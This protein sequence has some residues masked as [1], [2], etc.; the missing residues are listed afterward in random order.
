L[1]DVPE[2]V[3]TE[4][5]IVPIGDLKPHPRNARRGDVAKIRES[6]RAHGVFAPVLAQR[7]RARVIAHRHVWEACKAE[8]MTHV[9]VIWLDVNDREAERIM[10]ADNGTSD[11]A[12]YDEAALLALLEPLHASPAGLYGTSFDDAAMDRLRARVEGEGVVVLDGVDTFT[13]SDDD[14]RA[15]ARIATT[16]VV[17]LTASTE[18]RAELNALLDRARDESGV[19]EPIVLVLSA[20]RA[21]VT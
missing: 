21:F 19:N 16:S 11:A 6:I 17:T 4:I 8:E 9:P 1:P 15:N 2:I 12:T 5:I 7:S 13:P 20:L 3:A 14:V 10:L 18:Q